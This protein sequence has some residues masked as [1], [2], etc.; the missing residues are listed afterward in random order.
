MEDYRVCVASLEALGRVQQNQ[1]MHVN[2][3][4]QLFVDE[5]AWGTSLRRAMSA[6]SR[7]RTVSA[8]RAVVTHTIDHMQ[9]ERAVVQEVQQL[10]T[11]APAISTDGERRRENL[12]GLENIFVQAARG[13]QNLRNS[14]YATDD[15]TRTDLDIIH[16]SMMR[17]LSG[18]AVACETEEANLSQLV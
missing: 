6:D 16:A 8:I 14:T 3:D 13:I 5:R 15:C 7:R 18:A 4:G 1:K 11:A 12:A 2:E 17:E 10:T 9:R